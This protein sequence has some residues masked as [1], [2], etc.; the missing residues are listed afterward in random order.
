VGQG[1]Q[2]QPRFLPKTLELLGKGLRE[3]DPPPHELSDEMKA[4][5]AKLEQR[6]EGA[7]D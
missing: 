5:L 7:Y 1:S 4:L 3:R 2:K 6:R